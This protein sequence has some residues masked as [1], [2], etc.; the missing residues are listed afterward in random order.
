MTVGIERIE[1]DESSDLL[2]QVE[3]RIPGFWQT[4]TIL[5]VV[6]LSILLGGFGFIQGEKIVGFF[7]S[8]DLE[9]LSSLWVLPKKLAL[10]SLVITAMSVSISYG[11]FP[12]G[13]IV[14]AT[15]ARRLSPLMLTAYLPGLFR[16][17]LWADRELPHLLFTLA[18]VLALKKLVFYSL[19][20][21]PL[22]PTGISLFEGVR[23]WASNVSSGIAAMH[24]T[25]PKALGFWVVL[26]GVVYYAVFFSYHTIV[27]HRNVLSASFDLGL[28]ENII[29]NI[30]HGAK[31]ILK[32]SPLGGPDAS[33]LGSHATW[34]A[35]LLAPFYALWPRAENI[36]IIQAVLM[37]GAAI[38]LYLLAR[39]FLNPT[40]SVLVA[41]SY[42]FFPGLHGAALYDFHY[43]PLGP[44]FLWFV[45]YFT[46]KKR[47]FWVVLFALISL[48][49]RED[50]AVALGFLGGLWL[51]S[52]R[53][54]TA[55]LGLLV[56]G[57]AYF[58]IMKGIVMHRAFGGGDAFVHQYKL[59][60]PEGDKGFSGVIKTILSNPLYTLS[61]MLE[62][63]KL[64][65]FLQIMLPLA[66]LPMRRLLGLWAC[67]PGLLFALLSTEYPPLL[68][69]SF[70]YTTYWSA[71][72]FPAMVLIVHWMD[73]RVRAGVATMAWKYSWLAAVGIALLA[74]TYQYG[75][76]LQHNTTEGGFGRYH[77]GTD[78][79]DLERR[80][81][82]GKILKLVPPNA[83]VVSSE[84]IVPQLSNRT[85][86]YTLRT[87]AYDADYIIFRLPCSRDEGKHVVRAL[88]S[89]THGIVLQ[90]GE[91]G[92]AKRGHSTEKNEEYISKLGGRR[93][94]E[95]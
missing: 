80:Q 90:S 67:V 3:S 31:P 30:W 47:W 18:L 84:N 55:A 61:T 27:H 38:P 11:A 42:L 95:D 43:L 85:D 72:L 64:I 34:F 92:L 44:F 78:G 59:L 79:S 13:R 86:A 37:G 41:Y 9:A 1:D 35:Y 83:K 45:L 63:Q 88:V 2:I 87:G 62:R 94:D 74:N 21:P 60:I 81:N 46:E 75:A 52:G 7:R 28:E 20:T 82:L 6:G 29:Y 76:L 10:F 26:L 49:V 65:Y 73:E 56:L 66:F 32:S 17:Q 33:H 54:P 40:L 5:S 93:H 91:F 77:F 16:W 19:S 71:Q 53:R 22:E 50:V 24:R 36:L 69:I 58:V 39:R 68:K 51:L 23:S 15:L 8:D 89:G 12:R 25:I 4:L 48:S 14:L 70:Q 57:G